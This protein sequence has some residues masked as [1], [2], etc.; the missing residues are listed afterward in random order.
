MAVEGDNVQQYI[1]SIVGGA[2]MAD[3]FAWLTGYTGTGTGTSSSGKAALM[4]AALAKSKFAY[5]QEQDAAKLA[6]EQAAQAAQIA[7]LKNLYDTG[8]GYDLKG[9][10]GDIAGIE[11]Q[12][13]NAINDQLAQ[14]LRGL[15]EGY[16]GT[17]TMMGAAPLTEQAYSNLS[18]Y[19]NQQTSNPFAGVQV[20][21]PQ[22][23]NDF[24]ALL[25]SQGALS[26][27]VQAYL[28]GVNTSLA[29]GAAN[30]QNLLSTLAA[31]ETSGQASRRSE[32]KTAGTMAK[33]N[34]AQSRAAMEAQLRSQANQSLTQLALQMA[35]ERMQAKQQD[36]ATKAKIAET[37]AQ[38]G[39]IV[40]PSQL[41]G[42]DGSTGGSTGGSTQP[43]LEDLIRQGGGTTNVDQF[44]T[45][46]D[47]LSRILSGIGA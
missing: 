47:E 11:T 19:L 30:F 35:Q 16:Q 20:Q 44:Q 2:D 39:I 9:A 42:D 17:D 32:A 15:T 40:D 5:Q 4:N 1:D 24:Q 10:L 18:D 37:L 28:Q 29:G 13:Q 36:A 31:L 25:E 7:A 46:I 14:S 26:P 34:L 33:T 23:T 27:N 22:A 21:T 3:P 41:P 43:T 6:R 45:G 38:L 8:A 12:S